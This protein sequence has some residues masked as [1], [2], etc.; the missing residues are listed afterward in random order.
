MLD[1]LAGNAALK[2]DLQTA[3][4]SG[5]L[6]HS[7][8][9]VGEPGCGAGFAA[10]CLAADF[11]Y[12]QGGP[13]AEAVL[14]GQDTECLELRG[15][16]RSGQIRVDDVRELRSRIQ[17]SALSVD[18]AGRALIFYDAQNLNA[19]SGNALLKIIEEPPRD[20]LFLFAA[21]SAAAVLPTIRS[22]CAAYTMS[23][24]P[25]QECAA[26][27]PAES[28]NLAFLYEGHL[29]TCL[30]ALSDPAVRKT[31]DDAG[32]LCTCADRQDTY[33]AL[34]LLA[35]YE[36]EREAALEL[37]WQLQQL[38]S[39][40]MRR[41]GFGGLFS[42]HPDRP[43]AV[44]LPA[45]RARRAITANGSLRLALTVLGTELCH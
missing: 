11:I 17:E 38:C 14:R 36:K 37:L 41:P 7:I 33:R 19:S 29:G 34:T 16:G 26:R 43:G 32:A 27:L 2:A 25:E 45:G 13:H 28:R 4:R 35:G 5:R 30:R 6:A 24:V 31:L 3:L 9:L 10:R 1:R 40:C 23:P 18:A 8:L 22:R 44:S 21:S 20:V 15:G 12:P 39:A 42:L